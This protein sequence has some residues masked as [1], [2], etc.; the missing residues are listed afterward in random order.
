MSTTS[1]SVSDR[2]IFNL[3]LLLGGLFLAGVTLVAINAVLMVRLVR[4]DFGDLC[5]TARDAFEDG[6]PEALKLVLRGVSAGPKI[7]VHLLDGDGRDL[8]TGEYRARPGLARTVPGFRA[9]VVQTNQYSCV[10]DPPSGIPPMPLGPLSWVL[11]FVS[12]LCCSMGAYVSWRMRRIEAV[13]RHFGS[14]ALTV[15]MKSES[16]DAIG[17]LATAFNHMA[18]RIELLVDS[19][20]RLCADM[21]HELR[22]PLTRLLLAVR[23]ARRG[24]AGS[25][26]Q[27]EREA[28]RIDDLVDQLLEVA[29]TE[30]D[31]EGLDLELL[32]LE[33]L[34]IEIADHCRIEALERGCDIE[35]V[36]GSP[37]HVMA[38]AELLR[39]AIEN[40]LRN[41][42]RHTEEGTRIEL[43]GGGDQGQALISI[44][45]WGPGVPEESL[46]CIFRPFYRVDT[47]R[48]PAYGGVGLGLSIAYRAVAVHGGVIVAENSA[49]GLRVVIRVPRRV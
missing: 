33:S 10:A 39:R 18:E 7:R 1:P 42:I 34:L 20:Q 38:D 46:A 21:A 26:D 15:R 13:I 19:Q 49:P 27:L 36:T 14:G 23:G 43:F 6:G 2:R 16:R 29:R 17:R 5:A 9:I 22:S 37:G 40:V 47:A 3:W 30:V 12:L 32:D 41:A 35:L 31:P 25:L 45:D 4:A 11:P 44:R 28:A 24:T 48:T 8:A